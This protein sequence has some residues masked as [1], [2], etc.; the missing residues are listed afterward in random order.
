MPDEFYPGYHKRLLDVNGFRD[1]KAVNEI[2]AENFLDS[3]LSN[4][5]SF[6][7]IAFLL[8]IDPENLIRGHTLIPI[9]GGFRTNKIDKDRHL[10]F[11]NRLVKQS[12]CFCKECIKE[13]INYWGFS[14]WRKSHQLP[15]VDLCTKHNSPLIMIHMSRNPYQLPE[16]YLSINQIEIGSTDTDQLRNIHIKR[17]NQLLQ[18]YC[19][20]QYYLDPRTVSQLLRQQAVE[21]NFHRI[22]SF[23]GKEILREIIFRKFPRSWICKH[24]PGLKEMDA[25]HFHEIFFPVNNPKVLNTFLATVILFPDEENILSYLIDHKFVPTSNITDS[26]LTKTYFKCK[27]NVPNVARL[28]GLRQCKLTDRFY[29]LGCP[30]LEKLSPTTLIALKRF[31]I[32]VTLPNILNIEGLDIDEFSNILRVASANVNFVLDDY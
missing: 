21:L 25:R 2:L 23:T 5:H 32:G 20:R 26:E 27:G 6:F 3:H 17:F 4:S 22:L 16:N 8:K 1:K 29:K 13:D 24:F 28:L 12:P 14:Y 30:S 18:D 7:Q 11:W 9:L 19:D 31:Y 10:I 15:G